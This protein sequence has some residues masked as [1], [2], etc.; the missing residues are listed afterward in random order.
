MQL[1]NFHGTSTQLSEITEDINIIEAIGNSIEP[2]ILYGEI[3]LSEDELD[4]QYYLKY[5]NSANDDENTNSTLEEA[6]TVDS[7]ITFQHN[8]ETIADD[9]IIT[10]EV[11]DDT[12]SVIFKL[13]IIT[14]TFKP[15][16]YYGFADDTILT[17]DD[18]SAA[19]TNNQLL[20]KAIDVTDEIVFNGINNPLFRYTS[21]TLFIAFDNS[22]NLKDIIDKSGDSLVGMFSKSEVEFGKYIYTV[23]SSKYP[24]PVCHPAFIGIRFVFGS[25]NITNGFNITGISKLSPFNLITNK[26]LD[27]RLSVDKVSDL[28]LIEYPYDGMLTWVKDEQTYYQYTEK[29]KFQEYNK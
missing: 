28:E 16:V 10:V 9:T 27:S 5:T 18:L 6:T 29:N 20:D 26:P 11:C 12:K 21:K 24:L 14:Y 7:T 15:Y 22:L 1:K 17:Q 13:P 8:V 25:D 2:S 19:T 3:A 23:Y 4:K